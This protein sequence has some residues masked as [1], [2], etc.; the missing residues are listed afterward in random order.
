MAGERD[1]GIFLEWV[2]TFEL[3]LYYTVGGK[4]IDPAIIL[5]SRTSAGGLVPGNGDPL[6]GYIKRSMQRRDQEWLENNGLEFRYLRE[7]L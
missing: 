3:L 5:S 6:E 2:A 1:H 4:T 7:T